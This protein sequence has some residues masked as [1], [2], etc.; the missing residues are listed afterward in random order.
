MT[1]LRRAARHSKSSV[2][3]I[4][5]QDDA[6]VDPGLV[7]DAVVDNTPVTRAPAS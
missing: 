5:D 2:S 7:I 1:R 4:L 6:V 3:K